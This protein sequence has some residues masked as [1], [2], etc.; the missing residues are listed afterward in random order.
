MRVVIAVMTD[1][2]RLYPG[3]FGHSPAFAVYRREGAAWVREALLKN[4]YA[5]EEG[6]GKGRKLRA[7]F[8]PADLWIGARFGH[9]H[10]HGHAPPAPHRETAAKTVAEAL[11]GL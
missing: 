5:R 3:P 8:G 11:E 9:G 1:G 7:L 2:E 10:G 6:G 4:P